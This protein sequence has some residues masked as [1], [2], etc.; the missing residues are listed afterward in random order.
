MGK[1]FNEVIS[2]MKKIPTG[3]VSRKD[4]LEDLRR[5]FNEDQLQTKE[6]PLYVSDKDRTISKE[7]QN[8]E[9]IRSE[10]ST[11]TGITSYAG[12]EQS[13]P[14]PDIPVRRPRQKRVR[15]IGKGVVA[16]TRNQ[17]GS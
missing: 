17:Q 7:E 3:R 9:P 10:E 16:E 6:A 4:S 11:E 8:A 1:F 2:G 13:K 14:G 5:K 15:R 12:D